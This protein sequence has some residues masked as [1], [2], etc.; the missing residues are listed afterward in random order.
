MLILLFVPSTV[1]LSLLC[2]TSVLVS[3]RAAPRAQQFILT[4][5]NMTVSP[6]SRLTLPCLVQHKGGEC[7]WER[8][9]L[10]VGLFPEKYR[11][12]DGEAG[13]CSLVVEDARLEWDEG[14]WQCQVSASHIVL[15]DSL[16]SARAR[17]T[18]RTPPADLEV[19]E[20]WC[21]VGLA[22]P[23][24]SI[25]VMLDDTPLTTSQEDEMLET[26]GWRSRVSVSHLMT[27]DNNGKTL[28]CKA[29]HEGEV[30][31]EVELRLDIPFPP[32]ILKVETDK[33]LYRPGDSALLT[34]TVTSNPPASV[35]WSRGGERLDSS[36]EGR[37]VIVQVDSDTSGL[38]TCTADNGLGQA[39]SSP[40][41]LS[42]ARPPVILNSSLPPLVE[43][44]RGQTLSVRCQAEGLPRPEYRWL[45]R[46]SE[47]DVKLV[48]EEQQLA[49]NTVD[50]HT[51]GQYLCE[52]TNLLGEDLSHVITVHIKGSPKLSKSASNESSQLGTSFQTEIE[53][54][55]NPVPDIIWLLKD[56]KLISS[57]LSGVSISDDSSKSH[58]NCY[59]SLLRFDSL[60][61]RH[62]GQYQVVL[63]NS[64]GNDT[65]DLQLE[66][67][68]EELTMSG[69]CLIAIGG[70]LGAALI[71]LVLII[72]TVL[73]SL[74]QARGGGK[75]SATA[76]TSTAQTDCEVGQGE[77]Q[78]DNCQELME[79]ISCPPPAPPAYNQLLYPKSS[80]CGS[81]R[82]KKEEHY[83]DMMNIYHTAIKHNLSSIYDANYKRSRNLY[84]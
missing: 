24:A 34:C 31:A 35:S 73:S 51:A 8:D 79:N 47:G 72:C 43:L 20:D 78:T 75:Q 62:S 16:I 74:R 49:V 59:T 12:V 38:Y 76:G 6:G 46:S 26:G 65:F 67:E 28:S 32:R 64:L 23:P 61:K 69:E 29:E 2:F 66:V 7:R 37:L 9:G 55:A 54:C 53:F 80:N 48:S 25:Q 21:Q 68:G 3:V 77:R 40:V 58:P 56:E 10:P 33:E 52:A 82:R 4:P 39:V 84:F 57:N 15:A 36:E 83:K 44:S 71:V 14:W 81:M 1:S 11:M 60:E 50:Y 30:R 18:V 63:S 41:Q 19:S 22:S 70:G 13:D 42:L 17:L 45:H 27:P 5:S